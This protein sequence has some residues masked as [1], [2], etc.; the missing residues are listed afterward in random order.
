MDFCGE[1]FVPYWPGGLRFR[2]GPVDR[3]V[4]DVNLDIGVNDRLTSN[5]HDLWNNSKE[6]CSEEK[7]LN[8]A[9][10]LTKFLIAGSVIHKAGI[11]LKLH[12][13]FAIIYLLFNIVCSIVCWIFNPKI[14]G[15][16]LLSRLPATIQDFLV[17]P[18]ASV[19]L[20]LSY[21][22]CPTYLYRQMLERKTSYS[23]IL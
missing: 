16:C 23:L 18:R 13:E 14:T 15:S 7:F 8:F 1:L 6:R 17:H 20:T 9:A 21:V 19:Y 10:S 3:Y 5:S 2:L 11:S 4:I 22:L 12:K